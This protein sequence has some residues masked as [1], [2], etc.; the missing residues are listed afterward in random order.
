MVGNVVD[1][2][3]N[4]FERPVEGNG[5][6]RHDDRSVFTELQ[7]YNKIQT[8]NYYNV[9]RTIIDKRLLSSHQASSTHQDASSLINLY[10]Q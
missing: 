9:R 10:N 3:V 1:L 8:S 2:C 7:L 4:K 6:S 5:T